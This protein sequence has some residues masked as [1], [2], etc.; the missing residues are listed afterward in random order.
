[1]LNKTFVL[2]KIGQHILSETGQI[3][4]YAP[5]NRTNTVNNVLNR[6]YVVNECIEMGQIC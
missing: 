1:M 4:N 5:Q 2:N 6:T 3:C